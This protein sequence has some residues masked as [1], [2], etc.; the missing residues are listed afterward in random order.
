MLMLRIKVEEV[1]GKLIWE[2]Y[3]EFNDRQVICSQNDILGLVVQ[4]IL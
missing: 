2:G 1:R 3:D 4:Q